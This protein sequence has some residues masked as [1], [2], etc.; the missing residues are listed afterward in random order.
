MKI[1]F[2]TFGLPIPLDELTAI[3]NQDYRELCTSNGD[4][5]YLL[6]MLNDGHE[7]TDESQV[8]VAEHLQSVGMTLDEAL[9]FNI[10][11]ESTEYIKD[12]LQNGSTRDSV[13]KIL[14]ELHDTLKSCDTHH[15]NIRKILDVITGLDYDKPLYQLYQKAFDGI[16]Y[17]VED[18]AAKT[19]VFAAIRNIRLC[20]H[21]EEIYQNISAVLKRSVNAQPMILYRAEKK[22]PKSD[23]VHRP[24]VISAS[25]SLDASFA[26]YDDKY[27]IVYTL[28]VP[29][30]V[31]CVDISSLSNYSIEEEV[32]LAGCDIYILHRED[33]D[34][35]SMIYGLVQNIK[36][37]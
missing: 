22:Y 3:N 20:Y 10:L 1:P 17:R 11:S 24:N 6:S 34:G 19:S 35:K 29:Q 9:A 23:F 25:K 37:A 4:I 12:F 8:K 13:D 30:G 28:Y 33:V 31:H 15:K 16:T 26:K 21:M 7:L 14:K 2:S 5:A 27:N 18:S 36:E 32:V